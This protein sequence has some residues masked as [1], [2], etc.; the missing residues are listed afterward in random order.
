[1]DLPAVQTLL[2]LA[3]VIYEKNDIVVLK[4]HEIATNQKCAQGVLTEIDIYDYMRYERA[5]YD[6]FKKLAK[7]AF[8]TEIHVDTDDV[9]DPAWVNTDFLDGDKFFFDLVPAQCGWENAT[10]WY[11]DWFMNETGINFF[12]CP[13]T[14]SESQKRAGASGKIIWNETRP[15]QQLRRSIL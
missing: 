14:F 5:V 8:P 6:I 11:R 15:F 13:E 4:D 2:D 12:H 1:M 10:E 7:Q 3:L 9:F